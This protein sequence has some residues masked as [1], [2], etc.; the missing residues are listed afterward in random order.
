M[1]SPLVRWEHSEDW[2]VMRCTTEVTPNIIN[3]H[4]SCNSHT[5]LNT[6]YCLVQFEAT[7]LCSY[8]FE[9]HQL[10]RFGECTFV[11]TATTEEIDSLLIT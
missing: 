2:Y 8:P 9:W 10:L 7:N 5:Q 4:V 1:I 3:L 11:K 6:V